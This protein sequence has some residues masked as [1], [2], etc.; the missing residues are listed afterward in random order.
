MHTVSAIVVGRFDVNP[1]RK[2]VSY[3][4]HEFIFKCSIRSSI[5][6]TYFIVDFLADET[7]CLP[8]FLLKKD[9]NKI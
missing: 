4:W 2:R 8:T 9:K 5:L 3:Q 7:A 6:I 1:Q